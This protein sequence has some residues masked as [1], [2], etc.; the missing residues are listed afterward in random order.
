MRVSFTVYNMQEI[1]VSHNMK[2][3]KMNMTLYRFISDHEHVCLQGS[4][5]T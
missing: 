1:R 2:Q 5:Y 3:L 4:I